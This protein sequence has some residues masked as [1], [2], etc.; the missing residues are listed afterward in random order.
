MYFSVLHVTN[1]IPPG[2]D[3][4]NVQD[5]YQNRD[6]PVMHLHP[7]GIC[8]AWPP[9]DWFKDRARDPGLS[10]GPNRRQRQKNGL[11]GLRPKE[12]DPTLIL[13]FGH[14][15]PLPLPTQNPSL[16]QAHNFHNSFL[17]GSSP[18]A[19]KRRSICFEM[20]CCPACCIYIYIYIF[21]GWFFPAKVTEQW[22]R[23]CI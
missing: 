11:R 1:G 7:G 21:C 4:Q 2:V 12:P 15:W 14:K 19:Q 20:C 6:P 8:P 3:L 10:S 16:Y 13:D 9:G 23:I 18:C 5:S 22:R 17:E